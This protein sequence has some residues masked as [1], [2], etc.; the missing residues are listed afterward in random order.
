MQVDVAHVD[1]IIQA[2]RDAGIEAIRIGRPV[3]GSRVRIRCGDAVVLDESRVDLHLAWSAT[4]HAMQRMRD[5]P[6]AADQE[7]A[8]LRDESDPGLVPLLT[9]D[10]RCARRAVREP[11]SAPARCDPA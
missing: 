5:N 1:D 2:A 3:A 7:Y 11:R 10:S 4:T 9:F 8:R 6:Q